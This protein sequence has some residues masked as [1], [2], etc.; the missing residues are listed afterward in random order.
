MPAG[1]KYPSGVGVKRLAGGLIADFGTKLVLLS[2]VLGSTSFLFGAR[3][4][5]LRGGALC[6]LADFMVRSLRIGKVIDD[7]DANDAAPY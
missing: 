2:S 3:F 5:V 4:A 1:R 6:L 7:R